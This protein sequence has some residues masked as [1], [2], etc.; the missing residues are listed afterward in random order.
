MLAGWKENQENRNQECIRL[1]ENYGR[2]FYTGGIIASG[3][4]W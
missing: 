1:K 2:L 4:G 3:L